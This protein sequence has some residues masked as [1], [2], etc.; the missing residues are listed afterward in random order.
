MGLLDCE[1]SHGEPCTSIRDAC[2][3]IDV[4]LGL[5]DRL[6]PADRSAEDAALRKA[7][8]FLSDILRRTMKLHYFDGYSAKEI[9]HIKYSMNSEKGRQPVFQGRF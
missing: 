9:A 5:T 8:D 4:S 7:V 3:A 2:A 6:E 1:G